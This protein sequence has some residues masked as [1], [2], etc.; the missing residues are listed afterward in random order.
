M[1]TVKYINVQCTRTHSSCSP[2]H[3]GHS[4][5]GRVPLVYN[6]FVVCCHPDPLLHPPDTTTPLLARYLLIKIWLPGNGLQCIL[7]NTHTRTHTHTHTHTAERKVILGKDWHANC[8]RCDNCD[9]VLTPGQ[10]SA[11]SVCVCMCVCVCV[12]VC[13]CAH[14]GVCA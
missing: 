11:V 3:W 10:H 9:K 5:H 8:L 13:V 12:C 7:S 6:Y 2:R 1:Y 14:V 4:M